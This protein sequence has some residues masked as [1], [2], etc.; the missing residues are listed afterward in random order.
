MTVENSTNHNNHH[1]LPDDRETLVSE[2]TVLIGEALPEIPQ[3]IEPSADLFDAGLDSM[4]IMQ[5]LIFLE[6]R[7]GVEIPPEAVTRE[8][9]S[10]VDSLAALL[11]AG[12][13]G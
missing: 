6:D 7:Y 1:P 10:T 13:H 4:A 8:N 12:K 11:I 3:D 2:L 5:L 9:F